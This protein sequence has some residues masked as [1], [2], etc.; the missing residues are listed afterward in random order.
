MSTLPEIFLCVYF[1]LW[2]KNRNVLRLLEAAFCLKDW[3][4]HNLSRL[5]TP[6]LWIW[7]LLL[8]SLFYRI[9]W[10]TARVMKSWNGGV[11]FANVGNWFC[12]YCC[13]DEWKTS[14][15]LDVKR[16]MEKRNEGGEDDDDDDLIWFPLDMLWDWRSRSPLMESRCSTNPGEC[17]YDLYHWRRGF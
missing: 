4:I 13:Q 11:S 9:V 3:F 15:L 10:M 17:F 7:I 1:K 16:R 8:H 12:F 5:C 6:V 2:I 14:M